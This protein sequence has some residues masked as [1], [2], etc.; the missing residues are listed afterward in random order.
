[1]RALGGDEYVCGVYADAKQTKH[2][3]AS[4]A[5]QRGPRSIPD[6][7]SQPLKLPYL[8]GRTVIISKLEGHHCHNVE[9]RI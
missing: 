5:A 3:T 7:G 9:P 6:S 2:V 4:R 8:V 1:M